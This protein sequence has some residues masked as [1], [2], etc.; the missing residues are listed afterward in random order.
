MSTSTNLS[1][2]ISLKNTLK[3]NKINV[4]SFYN[5]NNNEHV[6]KL[7]SLMHTCHINKDI[8][9]NRISYNSKDF[10]FIMFPHLPSTT[11]F[12][13]YDSYFVRPFNPHI[14]IADRYVNVHTLDFIQNKNPLI[15]F[16]HLDCLKFKLFHRLLLLYLEINKS[17]LDKRRFNK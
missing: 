9:P 1:K 6:E 3:I 2:I 7:Q 17:M 15:P 4:L 13:K 12:K 10:S 8:H 16:I 11:Q 14:I 5:K